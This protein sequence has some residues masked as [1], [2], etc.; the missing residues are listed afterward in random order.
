MTHRDQRGSHDMRCIA[1]DWRAD[2][3]PAALAAFKTMAA[4]PY[5]NP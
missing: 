3:S 2:S 4:D 5:F 1:T